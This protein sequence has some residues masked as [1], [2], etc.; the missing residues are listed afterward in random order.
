ME[1]RN[2][3]FEPG[4]RGPIADLLASLRETMGRT[5]DLLSLPEDLYDRFLRDYGPARASKRWPR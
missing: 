5:G 1:T 3:A 4:S 2:L